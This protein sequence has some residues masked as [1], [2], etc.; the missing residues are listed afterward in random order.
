M[1]SPVNHISYFL[2]GIAQRCT[3]I[4]YHFSQPI[5]LRNIPFNLTKTIQQDEWHLLREY[6]W[7]RVRGEMVSFWT[8]IF[9]ASPL[10]F[11]LKDAGLVVCGP[12]GPIW[13]GGRLRESFHY[14]GVT[15]C[16][17][18]KC[19]EIRHWG[20]VETVQCVCVCLP[21]WRL[22]SSLFFI[23]S[24][25]VRTCSVTYLSKPRSL[26]LSTLIFVVFIQYSFWLLCL[27]QT[28]VFL[29]KYLYECMS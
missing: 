7:L 8:K 14:A 15:T 4:K 28:L 26:Y 21:W 23:K 6:F 3:A 9:P 24:S 12:L 19:V 22:Y 5:R 11:G 18:I 25:G 2:Q 1:H 20:F 13:L 17:H 27:S 10:R 29:L 16:L